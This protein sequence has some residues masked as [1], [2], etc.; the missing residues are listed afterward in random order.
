MLLFSGF[1]LGESLDSSD[2]GFHIRRF[3]LLFHIC[4]DAII[5]I[6][7]MLC[8]GQIFFRG[9]FLPFP[10]YFKICL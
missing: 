7:S 6:F 1:F 3:Y 10:F 4:M 2:S 9:F 8:L 5:S